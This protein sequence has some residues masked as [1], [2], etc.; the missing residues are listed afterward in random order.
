MSGSQHHHKSNPT[1]YG[2]T[3]QGRNEQSRV[4]FY[5]N[6]QTNTKMDYYYTTG[7]VKTSLDHPTQGKTQ[8]F[9]RDLSEGQ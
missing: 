5:H 9:R 7:T 1:D 8:M 6:P 3:Y 4:D 2:Y